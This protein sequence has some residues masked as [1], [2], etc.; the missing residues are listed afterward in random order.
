M[1][2]APKLTK[3]EIEENHQHFTERTGLYKSLGLDFTDSRKFILKKTQPLRGKILE[4]G[5]GNGYTTL[6]LAKAGYK[7]ISIDNDREA[8][9]RAALNLAYEKLLSNVAFYVMDG[10]S[11][12]FNNGSFNN[13]IIVNLFHHIVKVKDILSETD[14]VLCVEGKLIMAD[15][16]KKAMEVINS[17]HKKEGHTHED[18][19]VTKDYVCSYYKDLGYEIK[20][21]KDKYHWVLIAEKKLQQ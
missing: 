15:F 19:G 10:K 2:Y 18:S 9:K 20:D 21:Y 6:L 16:N 4:I 3:K 13:V 17:V 14:R 5:S 8:L 7:F 12:S 1:K 11:L